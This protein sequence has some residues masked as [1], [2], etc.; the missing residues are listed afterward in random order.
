MPLTVDYPASFKSRS[1]LSCSGRCTLRAEIPSSQAHH[2]SGAVR[3]GGLAF[4]CTAGGYLCIGL[5]RQGSEEVVH[6]LVVLYLPDRPPDADLDPGK[7]YRHAIGG[8]EPL[9]SPPPASGL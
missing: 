2:S 5:C 9:L 3:I 7:E 4:G 8:C 6:R 1:V